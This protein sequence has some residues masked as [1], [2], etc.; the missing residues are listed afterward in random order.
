MS[1]QIVWKENLD[2]KGD[3]MKEEI[4]NAV[5]YASSSNRLENNHLSDSE[6]EAI[7]D[8]IM[9]GQT[10]QSFLFSV[11]EAVKRAEME[12]REGNIEIVKQMKKNKE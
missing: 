5:K 12:I 1:I 2:K 8:N 7:I 11:V 3:I 10:E 9:T 4:E 6:L